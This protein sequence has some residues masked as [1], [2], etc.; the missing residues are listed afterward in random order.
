MSFNALK[1][2]LNIL[3]LVLLP[4]APLILSFENMSSRPL[5]LINTIH[6]RDFM[7]SVVGDPTRRDTNYIEIQTDIN[8]FEENRF[9][10]SN[11]IVEP[12]HTRIRAY[13]TQAERDLYVPNAFFYADGR[14]TAAVTSDNI[15]EIT[16]HAFSLMRCVI[17]DPSSSFDSTPILTLGRFPLDTQAA[18]QTSTSTAATYPNGGA[19]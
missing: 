19:P 5:T 18:S 4:F 1:T 12:V 3:L 7:D 8:I 15:L 14:F 17:L 13:V 6:L 16:V 11:V 2:V 9:Y 10:S